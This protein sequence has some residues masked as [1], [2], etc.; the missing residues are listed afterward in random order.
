MEG[1]PSGLTDSELKKYAVT[2]E[3][4]SELFKDKVEGFGH[5]ESR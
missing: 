1:I 3:E 4:Y 5:L 2:E